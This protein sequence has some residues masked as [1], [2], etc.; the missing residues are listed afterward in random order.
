MDPRQ[1]NEE[2][3]FKVQT[4]EMSVDDIDDGLSLSEKNPQTWHHW[5]CTQWLK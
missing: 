4:E 1:L 2:V 3:R 5:R